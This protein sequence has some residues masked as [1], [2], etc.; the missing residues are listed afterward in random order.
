MRIL[1]KFVT[2]VTQY[3]LSRG[4]YSETIGGGARV[5]KIEAVVGETKKNS[6]GE[7]EIEINEANAETQGL[8][9]I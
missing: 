3:E 1:H 7:L 2:S 6:N 4:G 8:V 9:L 5:C